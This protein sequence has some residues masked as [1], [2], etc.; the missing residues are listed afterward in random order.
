M[1]A[2]FKYMLQPEKVIPSEV[3]KTGSDVIHDVTG[4]PPC[5]WLLLYTDKTAVDQLTFCMFSE[6]MFMASFF[7][8]YLQVM[9]LYFL[10]FL[11][12][13]TLL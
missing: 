7:Q 4:P 3:A 13:L 9:C 8:F 5:S 11:H 6:G 10:Y 2:H 1:K 12:C